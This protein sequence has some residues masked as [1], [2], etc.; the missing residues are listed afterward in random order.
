MKLLFGLCFYHA[1]VIER[2]RFGPLGW[3][4]MYSF[5]DTD[6]DITVAQLELC[7]VVV[8]VVGEGGGGGG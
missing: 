2:K 1:L 3:N 4:I 5:N 7:V 8:V 6:L